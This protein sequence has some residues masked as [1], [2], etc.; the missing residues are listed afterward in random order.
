MKPATVTRTRVL[1]RLA[2]QAEIAKT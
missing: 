2:S 1:P